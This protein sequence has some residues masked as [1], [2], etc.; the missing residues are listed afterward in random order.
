MRTDIQ[1]LL[2][3]QDRDKKIEII[4]QELSAIPK[5]AEALKERLIAKQKEVLQKKDRMQQAE[6]AVKRIDLDAE[7][8]RDT[9]N[10]LK[11]RQAET[12][13]N[14]EY[15]MLNFEI[16]RYGRE[17]SELETKELE[18]MEIVDECKKNYAD[19]LE[20][21]SQYKT[22]IGEEGK[23]LAEKRVIALKKLEEFK[24]GRG[25]LSSKA[26]KDLYELY[27]KLREKQGATAVAEV[28]FSGQCTGCNM[29]LPPSS[30]NRVLSEEEV[31]QCSECSR[32][33]YSL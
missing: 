10:K 2:L 4:E 26:P 17:V 28:T 1:S 31:V 19:A 7:T 9:V 33:L 27:S 29:K 6:L 32:I 22:T 16:D 12:K 5:E 18:Q 30:Y 20:S 3:I 13:K 14:D 15:Q 23:L 8:R 25:Q 21:F 24:A 11:T